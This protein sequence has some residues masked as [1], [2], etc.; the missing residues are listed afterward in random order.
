VRLAVAHAARSAEYKQVT[1]L[2]AE[3]VRKLDDDN[4]SRCAGK[5][6]NTFERDDDCHDADDFGG[7][8]D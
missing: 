6:R 4:E 5:G 8:D 1:V 3:I 2:F 7:L